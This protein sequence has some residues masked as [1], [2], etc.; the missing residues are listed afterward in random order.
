MNQVAGRILI[1]EDN[2]LLSEVLCFNLKNAGFE[3][4]AAENGLVAIEKLKAAAFDLLITDYQMP[5]VDGA[6]LCR[7]VRTELHLTHM[8]I[9]MCSAKGLEIDIEKLKTD[10]G[11]SKLLF[12]PFSVREIVSAARELIAASVPSLN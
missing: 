5:I 2:G 1:A 9:L 7:A 3:V 4:A 8:P 11:L 10:F 6:E 12:K